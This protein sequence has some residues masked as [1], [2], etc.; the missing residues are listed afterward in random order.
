[1]V[2]LIHTAI[3]TR[4][5][6]VTSPNLDELAHLPSGISHW[7]FGRFDLYRVNPPLVRMV[8][9]IPVMFTAN[10]PDWSS[11]QDSLYSRSEFY[12]GKSFVRENQFNTFWYFTLARLACIPFSLIGCLVAYRWASDLYGAKSG[13]VATLL[14][15]FC[16]NM[17]AWGASITP[18]AASASLGLLAVWTWWRWLK[19][20]SWKSSGTAGLCL[21]IALLSKSTWIFLLAIYPLLWAVWRIRRNSDKT[22]A[23]PPVRHLLVSLA[24]GIYI[25][26]LGYGFE[27]TLKTLGSYR[28]VSHA[29]SGV[30]EPPDGAN[31]FEQTLLEHFPVP[32]PSNFVR[33]IDV[34]K[35][36]FERGKWS[37][38]RGEQKRRGWWYYYLYAF[39]VKNP[40]G[41]L[42]LVAMVTLSVTR[43]GRNE[44]ILLVP[45][46]F[47]FALV[48]SQ[49]G[50]NRYY[51][52]VLPASPFLVVLISGLFRRVRIQSLR[53]GLIY[54]ALVLSIV[55]S[56]CVVP[57]SMS[58][59]NVL[60]GGPIGGARHL[61]DGNIDWG[62]DLLDLR[63]WQDGHPDAKPLYVAYFAGWDIA[64]SIAGIHCSEVPRHSDTTQP[65]PDLQPGWYA[66]SVNYVYGL[67]YFDSDTVDYGYFRSLHPKDRVGYSIL[68][69]HVE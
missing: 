34:Q 20:P 17:L 39:L 48:S 44:V 4:I 55:E 57:H 45:V 33:G 10:D 1:M 24:I 37:Y 43:M 28:F 15:A 12:V 41:F 38:L 31:R 35:L 59:F 63:K 23:A 27:G 2:L 50:F 54:G 66:V 5:A 30:E 22:C 56:V 58:F 6:F 52:Y 18:D 29:L 8:A 40:L 3:L 62:Q 46:L 49:T 65:P 13:L 64:P 14:Y 60:V 16:P 42:V 11:Y 19:V 67:H 26:N 21:G 68:I 53:G 7:E 61:L 51:R 9:A 32:L 25:L 36:D 69:Y 47:V